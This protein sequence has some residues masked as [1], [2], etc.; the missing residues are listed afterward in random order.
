MDPQPSSAND[1]LSLYEIFSVIRPKWK[2]LL[3]TSLC[4]GAAMY[5][6][7]HLIPPTF[8]A[9]ATF[10]A[11]QQQGTVA[12][13]L[14]SLGSISNLAGAAT[15]IKNPADQYVSL[16]QSRTVADRLIQRF[17][18]AEIYETKFQDDAR[19]EL[20]GNTRITAGKKDAL[21]SVEV[22]DHDPN[23]ASAIANAY[24]EELR[25]LTN[26]LALSESQQRRKFFEQQLTA[27]KQ[28]LSDAQLKLQES[29]FNSGALKNEPKA[30]AEAYARL[31]A[32]ISAS[33]VRLSALR[34]TLVESS[35]EVQ[36]LVASIGA[37]RSQLAQ[38]EQ[39]AKE[40]GS[41]DYIGAYRQ[42]KYQEALFDIYAR[43]FE[44]AR[45]DEAREGT[46]IQVLDVA[47]PPRRGML[48]LSTTVVVLFSL[49]A[50]VVFRSQRPRNFSPSPNVADKQ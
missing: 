23:R 49:S 16:M 21:V 43:Q 25:E 13:A 24:I 17:K 44:I 32:E 18:L 29:G 48:A 8:S 45:M 1:E 5:A 38:L 2:T 47:Q 34:R 28:A 7:S 3:A 22:D 37:L 10:I 14:Q 31:R 9:K 33:E 39:P 50:F 36:R 20:A 4:A 41:Q 27:T 15:G 40:S 46:L 11:P 42:F 19:K 35:T 6:A 26:G 12:S 30:A